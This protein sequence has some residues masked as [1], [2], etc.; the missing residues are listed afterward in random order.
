M[1]ETLYEFIQRTLVYPE[2]RMKQAALR[3]EARPDLR[4]FEPS[5]VSTPRIPHTFK[6]FPLP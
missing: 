6:H 5:F 2:W 3:A 1:N 4:P